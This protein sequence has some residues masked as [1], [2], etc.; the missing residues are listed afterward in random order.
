MPSRLHRLLVGFVLCAGVAA[1][2]GSAP[3][4]ADA[5][6]P[7]NP[8]PR[9]DLYGDPL[10]EGAVARLGTMRFRHGFITSAIAFAPDGKVL[11]STGRFPNGVCL[12]DAASGRPLQRIHVPRF[13]RSLA[14]SPDGNWLVVGSGVVS[15]LDVA[16]GK[17]LR[18]FKGPG[19]GQLEV[20]AFSSD[21]RT[22]AATE[23]QPQGDKARVVLWDA[24]TGKELRRLP[25]HAE[26]VTTL[27]FS[28]HGG[29]VLASG[30]LD[31][32]VRLWDV[33]TGKELQ[34]LQGHK[35]AVHVVAFAP[36]GKMLASASEEGLVQLWDP[37]TGK[38][39]R[40]LKGHTGYV[41]T[42]VFA[43]DG[44]VLAS[45]GSG[46]T[47][48]LWDPDT[49]KEIRRWETYGRFIN[50]LAFA[51]DGKLASGGSCIQLWDA[52]TGKEM[53]PA[54]AHSNMVRSLQFAADGKTLVSSGRDRQVLVWDLTTGR[55]SGQLFAGPLGPADAVL[56]TFVEIT[57]DGK[58]LAQ[59][60][61]DLVKNKQEPDIHLWDTVTGK[62]LRVLSGHPGR[63]Q[64]LAFTPDGHL[65]ASAGPDGIRL[66][67][68]DSGKELRHL[69]GKEAG[70]ALMFSPDGKLLAFIG[71]DQTIRLWDVA[72]WKEHQSWQ[73]T[74]EFVSTLVFS[75]DGQSIAGAGE[76]SVSVW[77]TATGKELV[78]FSG[79][80]R[81]LSLAF[82]PTGRV[83]AAGDIG[84]RTLPNGDGQDTCTIHL[85]E[86]VSGQ[87]IRRIAGPQGTVWSLAFAPDSR[88]LA[89]GGGDST[90]LVWDL[91]GSP[92]D[93]TSKPALPRTAEEL[94]TLWSDLAGDAATADRALWT[95]VQAPTQ[96]VPLLKERLRP[97]TPADAQHVA[98]LVADLGSKTLA[99]RQTAMRELEALGE[100]A[101]A[102]L[103]KVLE[104][105]PTL[106]TRQRLEQVL[107]KRTKDVIRQLRAVAALEHINTPPARQVL[108]ELGQSTPNPQV[109][110]AVDAALQR[111]AKSR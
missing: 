99:V 12:W 28:P 26:E 79:T 102:A 5:P 91:S 29:K 56:W 50:A 33:A 57:P 8:T 53:C 44:K 19:G 73:S 15:L 34:R 65:L 25:W 52:A 35:N 80:N 64:A 62:E 32:T 82:S 84:Q 97:E 38:P 42:V 108:E 36:D 76:S 14:F 10:P 105:N 51:P 55:D 49:G 87:E 1:P 86:V 60:G 21:G 100:A 72:G 83:L 39:L 81:I 41:G 70:T 96:S 40:Q 104:G 89:S 90:I 58:I 23:F 68:V 54:T 6:A 78:R 63:V 17:E 71:G 101:E 74:Q 16:T 27:A 77:T 66:W 85:W 18:R 47:I 75:P 24:V 11:A 30:G 43:P 22:L 111:L 103:R 69:K 98:K 110:Q 7:R 9:T 48:R 95:L 109:A 2:A 59:V 31:T 20:V 3:T 37:A 106:E 45:A 61:F 4:V 88:T 94:D 107:Q 93:G 46:G 92:A 13:A 67:D